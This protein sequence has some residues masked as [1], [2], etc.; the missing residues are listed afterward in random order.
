MVQE[1]RLATIPYFPQL[2]QQ[3]VDSV[4]TEFYRQSMAAQVVRVA[5]RLLVVRLEL[6]R[7]RVKATQEHHQVE[8]KVLRAVAAAQ[9]RQVSPKLRQR[10]VMA[11]Q[12]ARI[13]IRGLR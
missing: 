7:L 2:H 1:I 3:A 10:A 6:Q 4:L 12:V 5:H 13:V 8:F 11:A 9:A